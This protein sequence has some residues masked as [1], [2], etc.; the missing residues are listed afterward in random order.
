M[1]ELLF[2][3]ILLRRSCTVRS[4]KLNNGHRHDIS[5]SASKRSS[6]PG[7]LA[8]GL[9]NVILRLLDVFPMAKSIIKL[10]QVT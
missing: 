7:L 6:K 1:C 4:A 5:M 9:I 2:N 3:F 8:V 10:K